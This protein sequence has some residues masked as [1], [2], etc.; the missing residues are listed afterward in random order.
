MVFCCFNDPYSNAGDAY[1]RQTS[2]G[3]GGSY[4]GARRMNKTGGNALTAA[5]VQNF[6]HSQQSSPQGT[7]LEGKPHVG[8]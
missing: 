5:P 4:P 2:D 7:F 8:F 3:L 6:G 1:H